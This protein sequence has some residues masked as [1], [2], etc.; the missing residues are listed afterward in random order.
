MRYCDL[1][2]GLTIWKL[3]PPNIYRH[4][5]TLA[6]LE[7]SSHSCSLCMMLHR[8]IASAGEEHSEYNPQPIMKNSKPPLLVDTTSGQHVSR[9]NEIHKVNQVYGDDQSHG[10]DRACIEIE[11]QASTEGKLSSKLQIIEDTTR[12]N[13]TT[14]LNGFTHIGV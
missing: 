7:D 5:E 8:C 9:H 2:N 11:D 3:F 12:R 4:A 1:C 6:A 14:R 10:V 13:S